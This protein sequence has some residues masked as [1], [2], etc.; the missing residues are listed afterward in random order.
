MMSSTMSGVRTPSFFWQPQNNNATA[1]APLADATTPLESIDDYFQ[2]VL[3]NRIE[4]LDGLYSLRED[5][6]SGNSAAPAKIAIES[7]KSILTLLRAVHGFLPADRIPHLMLS[8]LPSGGMGITFQPVANRQLGIL[9]RNSGEV[10]FE[11]IKGDAYTEETIPAGSSLL[12]NTFL[13]LFFD[14]V[15]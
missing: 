10:E 3:N 8:P 7:T 9:L 5:W 12:S 14:L 2:Q 15:Y 13:R 6:I 4:Y 11:S 1:A